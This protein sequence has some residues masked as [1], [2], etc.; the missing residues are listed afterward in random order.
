M[1]GARRVQLERAPTAATIEDMR[2]RTL[3]KDGLTT[4]AIGYGAMVLVEGMYGPVDDERS[5]R[6]LSHAVDAD[7]GCFS[8]RFINSDPSG[9]LSHHSWG[10][11]IDLNQA[12]NGFGAKPNMDMRVVDVFEDRWG[13]T[14]GGRWIIPDGI[15]FEWIKFP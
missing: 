9:R 5:L 4:S 6:A 13:F 7:S 2:T 15:H 1:A 11:A 12:Q 14:W 3:G 8:A 10:I